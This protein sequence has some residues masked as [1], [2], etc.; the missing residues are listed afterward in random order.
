M[1]DDPTGFL[2]EHAAAVGSG[3]LEVPVYRESDL[4]F[5]SDGCVNLGVDAGFRLPYSHRSDSFEHL[6]AIFP[7]SAIRRTPEGTGVYVVY[8]TD[9]GGG[10]TSSSRR[11]TTACS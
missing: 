5:A 7:S 11:R 2:A 6:Q 9:A 3:P 10:S 1:V 8:D 4:I